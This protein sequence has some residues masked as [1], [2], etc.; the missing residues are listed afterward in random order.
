MNG[1][2]SAFKFWGP[3]LFVI[4]FVLKGC[5]AMNDDAKRDVPINTGNWHSGPTICHNPNC[6]NGWCTRIDG[7]RYKCP[8]CNK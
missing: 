5:L 1:N 3:T 7:P 2:G 4:Y 6:N 8:I